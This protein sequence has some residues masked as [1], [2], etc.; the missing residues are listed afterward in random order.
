MSPTPTSDEDEYGPGILLTSGLIHS[1]IQGIIV[2]Q[3][4]RYYED[5]YH[6]DTLSMKTYV[7]S[8]VVISLYVCYRQHQVRHLKPHPEKLKRAD[9]VYQL[10]SLGDHSSAR[11]SESYG[12]RRHSPGFLLSDSGCR[13]C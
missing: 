10:Q 2:S 11:R 8:I 12:S 5:Y 7:G 9:Y 6:L 4:G 1:F 13:R 3:A